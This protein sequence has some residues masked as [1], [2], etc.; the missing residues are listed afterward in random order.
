MSK[1]TI[2]R[3]EIPIDLQQFANQSNTIN[4]ESPNAQK[5]IVHLGLGFKLKN[6]AK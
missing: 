1:T 5:Q 4:I 6:N 2:K 3:S